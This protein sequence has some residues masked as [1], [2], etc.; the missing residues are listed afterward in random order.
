MEKSPLR[1]LIDVWPLPESEPVKGKT[2]Y[3]DGW[4]YRDLPRMTRDALD[5][6]LDIIGEDN[7]EWLSFADYGGAYRGQVMISPD[8]MARLKQRADQANNQ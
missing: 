5:A 2:L 3:A 1:Q 4:V 7:V 6:L 8:G